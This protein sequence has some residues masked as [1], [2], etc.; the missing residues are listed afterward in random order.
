MAQ[1]KKNPSAEKV[2]SENSAE[3]S[4]PARRGRRT[5]KVQEVVLEVV[6]DDVMMVS[7]SHPLTV[8]SP[9]NIVCD[10]DKG[11][12]KE[13]TGDVHYA[14]QISIVLKGKVEAAVG[15]HSRIYREG[16]TWFTMCWEPHAY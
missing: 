11:P 7:Q 3:K 5:K 1:N 16:E 2:F 12:W 14:L 9:F 13:L 6:L 10:Y 15:S 4:T 8:A